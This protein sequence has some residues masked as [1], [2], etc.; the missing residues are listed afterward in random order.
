M[1]PTDLRTIRGCCFDFEGKE[2]REQRI[3]LLAC[4]GSL[5]VVGLSLD[6]SIIS[7]IMRTTIE[8]NEFTF[9]RGSI[10]CSYKLARFDWF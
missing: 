4:I 3:T 9:L 7:D 1:G 6:T 5:C 2:K 8:M 10:V